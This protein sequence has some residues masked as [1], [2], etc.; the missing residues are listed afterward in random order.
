MNIN[1]QLDKE[2]RTKMLKLRKEMIKMVVD[3]FEDDV[4]FTELMK[5]IKIEDKKLHMLKE[6]KVILAD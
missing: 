6:R 4:A 3:G 1:N 2:I 5:R